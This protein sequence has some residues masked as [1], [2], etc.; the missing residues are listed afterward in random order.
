LRSQNLRFERKKGCGPFGWA[1]GQTSKIYTPNKEY[2]EL[3]RVI[4]GG[5]EIFGETPIDL[6][7]A[8]TYIPVAQWEYRK[9]KT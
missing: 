1:D 4:R 8:G 2:L 7:L 6:L 5:G 3:S 9:R